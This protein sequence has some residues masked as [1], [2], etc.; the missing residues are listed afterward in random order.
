M[1]RVFQRLSGPVMALS[2]LTPGG[3]AG[4]GDT[5]DRRADAVRMVD[6][7]LRARGIRDPRVLAAMSRVPRHR[8][9]PAAVAAEAYDDHPLPIG[10]GQ[11]ISQPYIVAFMT[12]AL[13]I[14]PDDVVLEIGT[15][16]GYQ[17]AVL[18]ELAR[19]VYTI[20]LVPALADRARDTLAAEGY[21]HVHVL[22]GNGYQGWP[23][24][25]PFDRIVVTAA[26][27]AV[28]PALVDQLKDGGTMILPVGPVYGAQEL[29][30]LTKTSTGVTTERSL[31]VQF[32]PMIRPPRP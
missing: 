9:V 16:S 3:D 25:A 23:E 4:A 30:I 29:R 2:A 28:P 17:A 5:Q 1:W 6:R 24:H 14:R 27:E 10:H 21:R 31:A 15:G 22:T 13:A 8:Y 18:G 26:P 7:Q 32:V 19:E 12:E 11:T 20:E